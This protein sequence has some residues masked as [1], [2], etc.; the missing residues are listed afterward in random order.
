VSK[1]SYS[2]SMALKANGSTLYIHL[3]HNIIQTFNVLKRSSE[4]PESFTNMHSMVGDRLTRLPGLINLKGLD[5]Q[6]PPF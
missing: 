5:G 4:H 2:V 6:T 1:S 3:V